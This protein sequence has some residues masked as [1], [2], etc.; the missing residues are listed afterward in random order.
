[1]YF[2]CN[3]TQVVVED[4]I[5]EGIDVP[6]KNCTDALSKEQIDMIEE[7]NPNFK[8]LANSLLCPQVEDI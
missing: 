4:G 1:M 8:Y 2:E 3:Y 7:E 6:L 5:I